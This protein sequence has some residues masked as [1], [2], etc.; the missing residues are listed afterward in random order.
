MHS[1]AYIYSDQKHSMLKYIAFYI[2]KFVPA[3]VS[4]TSSDS[5]LRFKMDSKAL[6]Q[7]YHASRFYKMACLTPRHIWAF[8]TTQIKVRPAQQSSTGSAAPLLLTQ[9]FDNHCAMQD[10]CKHTCWTPRGEILSAAL[11]A[12]HACYVWACCKQDHCSMTL[13]W[14]YV[15]EQLDSKWKY[16][17]MCGMLRN[18]WK[19]YLFYT[20]DFHIN[21]WLL[22]F[23]FNS[24]AG[25]RCHPFNRT[26]LWPRLRTGRNVWLWKAVVGGPGHILTH[27]CP[28]NGYLQVQ[29]DMWHDQYEQSSWTVHVYAMFIHTLISHNEL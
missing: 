14:Q 27:R 12:Y 26:D 11:A 2:L 19:F 17:F 6:A 20:V 16:L 8:M 25:S 4:F 3:T 21:F 29:R 7:Q 10:L 5:S 28:R 9:L 24:T 22:K 23:A 1:H 15:Y 13:G 18:K